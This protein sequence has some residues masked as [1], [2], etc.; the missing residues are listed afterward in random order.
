MSKHI[1]ILLT[2]ALVFSST[3]SLINMPGS[4]AAAQACPNGQCP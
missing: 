1:V 3:A 4:I 2:C